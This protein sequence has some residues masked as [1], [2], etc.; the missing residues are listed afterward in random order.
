MIQLNGISP[1]NIGSLG[2]LSSASTASQDAAHSFQDQLSAAITATLQKFGIDPSKFS[3]SIA[4][5][6]TSGSQHGATPPPPSSPADIATPSQNATSSFDDQYWAGQPTAVQA[7]RN[8]GDQNQRAMMAAQLAADGYKIDT[9][10]MV[11]GWDPSKV[12]G[13]RHDLGYTWV[14]ASFQNPIAEAP[15]VND[16]GSQPYDPMNPPPGSIMV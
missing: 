12:T 3:L 9:P 14:P 13:L 6:V 7:L 8:V 1:F 16:N 4:P 5:V 10:V 11:W 15:G 2:D